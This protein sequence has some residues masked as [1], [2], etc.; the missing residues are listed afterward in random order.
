MA[1]IAPFLSFVDVVVSLSLAFCRRH[2]P[3]LFAVSC[4]PDGVIA[5]LSHHLVD[6][7]RKDWCRV[8]VVVV[9]ADV[10]AIVSHRINMLIRR[11]RQGRG[12][13]RERS[14]W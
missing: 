10:T 3:L 11:G 14:Y 6:W 8:V 5:V 12:Q 9:L 4:A 1:F 13:E 7:R 2:L